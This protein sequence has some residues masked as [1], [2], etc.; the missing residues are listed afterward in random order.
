M[1]ACAHFIVAVQVML[2]GEWFEDLFGNPDEVSDEF[3]IGVAQEELRL[4]LGITSHP[5]SVLGKIHKVVGRQ[6]NYS[7]FYCCCCVIELHSEV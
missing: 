6:Y 7:T 1:C 5:T 4:H 3:I 2:G